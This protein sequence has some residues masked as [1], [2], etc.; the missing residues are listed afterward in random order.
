MRDEQQRDSRGRSVSCR[1]HGVPARILRPLHLCYVPHLTPAGISFLS[2]VTELRA[3]ACSHT[4]WHDGEIITESSLKLHATI[5]ISPA[6]YLLLH[7]CSLM[8][9]VSFHPRQ[10]SWH[11]IR[12]MVRLSHVTAAWVSAVGMTAESYWSNNSHWWRAFS[13]LSEDFSQQC[14]YLIRLD[15]FLCA[16]LIITQHLFLFRL[17]HAAICWPTS[18]TC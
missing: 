3:A 4:R 12:L 15:S 13:V 14:W 16:G 11:R 6:T 2:W 7:H 5:Q 10:S 8:L 17:I 18:S 1:P 9:F